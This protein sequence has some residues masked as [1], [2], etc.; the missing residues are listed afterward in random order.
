MNHVI[1]TRP[2]PLPVPGEHLTR[3]EAAL[4]LGRS[5]GTLENWAAANIGP[6]VVYAMNGSVLYTGHDLIAYMR[7]CVVYTE[8]TSQT[9]LDVTPVSAVLAQ[10]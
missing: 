4:Y 8:Q 2:L 7:D 3:A 1:A 9:S 10:R 5:I 6:P